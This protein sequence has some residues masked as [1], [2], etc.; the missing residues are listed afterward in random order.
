MVKI[1]NIV[2]KIARYPEESIIFAPLKTFIET[3][4]IRRKDATSDEKTRHLTKRH[5]IRRKDT[6]SGEKTRHPAKRHVI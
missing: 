4:V 6:S 3:P 5:V 2:K 1:K